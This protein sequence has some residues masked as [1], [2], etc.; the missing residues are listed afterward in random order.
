MLTAAA[1]TGPQNGPRSLQGL[2]WS[3]GE[4]QTSA[5]TTRLRLAKRPA[6]R[7]HRRNPGPME[8]GVGRFHRKKS[9]CD[10][11]TTL[12][13]RWPADETLWNIVVGNPP[14]RKTAMK[15]IPPFRLTA[16]PLNKEAA[17]LPPFKW[18]APEVG[19]RH[20][21]GGEPEFIQPPEWPACPGCG[22]KMSFYGQLDSLND[23]F[24]IADVGM[25]YVFLCFDCYKSVSIVQSG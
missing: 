6:W 5:A 23:E 18:A 25:I 15:Q 22:S 19:K 13:F 7:W 16:Q 9:N 12:R 2:S 3:S 1:L 10:E 17:D 14:L 11:A 24:C 4:H 20:K 21:L 8:Q